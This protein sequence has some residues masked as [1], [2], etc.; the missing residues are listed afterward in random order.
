M[1]TVDD[2]NRQEAIR[3]LADAFHDD[4]VMRWSCNNPDSMEPFFEITIELDNPPEELLHHG[5]TALVGFSGKS[6]TIGQ[7]LYRS[8]LR[9]VNKL[10]T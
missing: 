5:M 7:R 1:I 3:I 10:R 6:Q 9:F 4:A 2:S 8:A